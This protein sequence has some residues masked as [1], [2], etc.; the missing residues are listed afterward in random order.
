M[1]TTH[2]P[3]ILKFEIAAS[4]TTGAFLDT[5]YSLYS[6]RTSD[7]KIGHPRIVYANS[8]VLKDAGEYFIARKSSANRSAG[9]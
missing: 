9:L 3:E 7:G 6:S 4:I 8:T 2:L 5:A 1:P